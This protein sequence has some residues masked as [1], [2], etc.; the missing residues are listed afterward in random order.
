[1]GKWLQQRTPDNGGGT[2]EGYLFFVKNQ[3]WNDDLRTTILEI[4]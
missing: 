4:S 1:M 2:Y 3:Y